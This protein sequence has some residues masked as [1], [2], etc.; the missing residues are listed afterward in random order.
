MTQL[1]QVCRRL[2][3]VAFVLGPALAYAQPS[4]PPHQGPYC[5]QVRQNAVVDLSLTVDLPNRKVT[6]TGQVYGNGK[7]PTKLTVTGTVVVGRTWGTPI[8]PPTAAW[9]LLLTGVAASSGTELLSFNP[10]MTNDWKQGIGLLTV[11][12]AP[13]AESQGGPFVTMNQVSCP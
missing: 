11:R 2:V 7:A 6:G 4:P 5:F 8:Q 13:A 10:R 1:V 12:A 3:C 9:V